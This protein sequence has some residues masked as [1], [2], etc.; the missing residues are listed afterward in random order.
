MPLALLALLLSALTWAHPFG[1]QLYGHRMEVRLDRGSVQIDY[2]AEISTPDHLRDLRTWL[3]QIP[4]PTPADEDRYVARVLQELQTGITVVADGEL[5][6]LTALPVGEKSG[7]GDTRFITFRL[8]L[9]GELPPDAT[10][11]NVVNSNL[12]GAAA[13]F[14]TQLFVSDAVVVDACSLF[15]VKDGQLVADRSERWQAQEEARELR[16]AFQARSQAG[17]AVERGFRRLAEGGEVGAYVPAA[18]RL[19]TVKADPL[20]ALVRGEVT[21]RAVLLALLTAVILGALHGLSPGHGKALVAAYL[22]GTRRSY[23]QAAWLGL[24]VTATH[25]L[26]VYA[27]GIVAMVLAESFAPEK[28]LPWM[29]LASGLL[30]VGVGV[31]LVRTRLRAARATRVVVADPGPAHEHGHAHDHAHDH[32]HGHDHGHAHDPL[33]DAAHGAAHAQAIAASGD[34]WRSL[35]ALGVSGGLA[36][37]PSAMVLLL[38]AIGLQRIGLGLVLVAAFSVGLAILVT[39]L[40]VAVILLGDR[41][42]DLKPAGPIFRALPVMSAVFV[43]LLGLALS[44][45]GV[46]AV[47]AVLG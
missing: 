1:S 17:A 33:D 21:P 28:V 12:P 16:V 6:P 37:C 9:R 38:T 43:T 46:A 30:V 22:V 39:G 35:V 2:L 31:G 5:V 24:I 47:L 20:V 27:M 32:A 14:N 36:P 4:T 45:K 10:T 23:S 7:V 11:L 18:S 41:L 34:G 26:A 29:E 3:R 42:R 40:G 19:S 25:T 8:S 44:W 13:L 15:K